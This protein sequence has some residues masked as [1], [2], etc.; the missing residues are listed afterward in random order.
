MTVSPT[1]RR[2]RFAKLQRDLPVA[3]VAGEV[4]QCRAEAVRV[5]DQERVC[6]S[7]RKQSARVLLGDGPGN[8]VPVLRPPQ[9]NCKLALGS[10]LL[11]PD[12][13]IANT[14]KCCC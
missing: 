13:V 4:E 3:D 2:A 14:V 8:I 5:L 10:I 9:C 12:L 11:V 7:L 6:S 1:A